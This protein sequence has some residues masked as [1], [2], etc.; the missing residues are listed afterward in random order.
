MVELL[1][2]KIERFFSQSRPLLY[3]KNE[4]IVRFDEENPPSVF[5]VNEG[6][7]RQST[8]SQEGEEVTINIL[9]R[10]NFFPT[11]LNSSEII[12]R[13]NFQAMVDCTL[14]KA[15]REVFIKF[16]NENPDVLY[17]TSKRLEKEIHELSMNIENL[18]V[19]CG[20]KRLL[21]G[22]Y[23]LGKK[24][25]RRKDGKLILDVHLTQR[26][27]GSLVSLSREAVCRNFLLLVKEKKVVRKGNF[28]V[29]NKIE[30]IEE[31]LGY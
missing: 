30:L 13:Y 7:V 21:I 22:L 11:I 28:L 20:R 26:E 25:G 1:E 6:Y 3:K 4:V 14:R 29:L 5:L 31:I 12:N 8:I 18:F 19:N 17:Y 27:I 24:F 2:E 15:P 10:N 16:I 9:T 23:I